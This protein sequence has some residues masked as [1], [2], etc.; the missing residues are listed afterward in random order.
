MDVNQANPL[1]FRSALR[2]AGYS[3]WNF[4]VLKIL[5]PNPNPWFLS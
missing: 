3:D 5:D 4:F 1:G 2:A